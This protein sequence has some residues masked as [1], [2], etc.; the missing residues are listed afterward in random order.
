MPGIDPR[1]E[2]CCRS[3]MKPPSGRF[4]I[5]M[6][7]ALR[8]LLRDKALRTGQSLNQLC[9]SRLQ[10]GVRHCTAPKAS[11]PRTSLVSEDFL[12]QIVQRW[13]SDLLGV[14]LF[15]SAARGDATEDSDIDLL[16]V[17]R[18]GKRITRDLYRDWD[19]FCVECAGA[20]DWA[21]L[22]PHFASLPANVRDAGGLWHETALDGTPL[23]EQDRRVS[24]FLGS[25]RE[26][27]GLGKIRRR[28]LHGSLYWVKEFEEADA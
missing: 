28:M 9:V 4:V 13:R 2:L 20:Q 6:S 26:A 12:N 17:L 27:M 1:L 10:A 5:R 7:C 23:W 8:G 22:S 24:R 3:I 25:V 15:G 16:L 19:D 11:A 21:C 18:P 14:V